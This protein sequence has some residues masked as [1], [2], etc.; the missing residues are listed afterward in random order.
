[1]RTRATLLRFRHR[2][3][4]SLPALPAL[5]CAAA[6]AQQSTEPPPASGATPTAAATTATTPSA[7]PAAV[8]V[9]DRRGKGGASVFVGHMVSDFDGFKKFFEDGAE[10]RAKAG[11]KGHL[12]TRLSDG[13]VVVHLFAADLG[14]LKMTLASPGLEKYLGRPGSPDASLIWLAYD[15]FIKLPAKPP[16]EPTFSLL[17]KLRASDLPAL[18]NGFLERQRLFAD[19]G[20]IASGLH[21]SV[22]QAD[23]V[24]LHFVGTDAKKLEA[25]SQRP[26]FVAWLAT[27]GSTEAPQSFLGEDVS[28]SRAY[29]ADFN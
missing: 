1:M 16:T 10:E 3:L 17:L 9:I 29:Y 20:V 25:L 19:Y 14:A 8:G 24:F 28:R 27:R 13:R 7:D 23:L 21:H 11:V 22:D 4:H 12:L 15:E 5:L 18:R 26:E 2:V 6:C